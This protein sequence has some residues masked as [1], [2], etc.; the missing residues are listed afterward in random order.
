MTHAKE[1]LAIMDKLV[2]L[3]RDCPKYSVWKADALCDW[4]SYYWNRGTISWCLDGESA[5]GVCAIKLFSRLGQFLEP[6]VHE[7]CGR[8]AFIEIMVLREGGHAQKAML[9]ELYQRWG[10]QA[11]V[12]WDRGERTEGGAPRMF[13]WDQFQK[14]AERMIYGRME[15]ETN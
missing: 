4:F 5:T 8:Y 3:I 7:P 2:D 15:R 9:D 10:P 14:L 1:Y 6:F 13:R 11:V 12:M